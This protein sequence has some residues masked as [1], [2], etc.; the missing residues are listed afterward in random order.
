MAGDQAMIVAGVG[1]RRGASA[2]EIEKVVRLAL[3]V[4]E[5]P[6]ERLEVLATESE[7]A[8]EP[9]FAEAAHRLSA[10]MTACTV[11]DLDRVA[12][13]VLTLSKLVLESKGVPSIAEASALVVAGRNAR[14]LGTRVATALATCAVAIGD[15]R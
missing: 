10:K 9:A 7:K 15:G 1:F 2:D 12:G 4:F 6:A 3:G 11:E 13:Q 8:A 14:L 5:L